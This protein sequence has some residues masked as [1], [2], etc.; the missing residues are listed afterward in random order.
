MKVFVLYAK[1]HQKKGSVSRTPLNVIFVNPQDSEAGSLISTCRDRHGRHHG[2]HDLRRHN[3][4][5]RV[6]H[7]HDHRHD[8]NRRRPVGALHGDVLR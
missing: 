8:Y 4:R 2:H 7:R 5:V 6:D 3:R 1:T